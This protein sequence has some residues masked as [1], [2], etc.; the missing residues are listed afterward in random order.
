MAEEKKTEDKAEE[1][2]E[3]KKFKDFDSDMGKDPSEFSED[4]KKYLSTFLN[5]SEANDQ[6]YYL[7]EW[8]QTAWQKYAETGEMENNA[9]DVDSV[10]YK[11]IAT[12]ARYTATLI[13][14]AYGMQMLPDWCYTSKQKNNI[15]W[16]K[17]KVK[18][19]NQKQIMELAEKEAKKRG[20]MPDEENPAKDNENAKESEGKEN[21]AAT[22][23]KRGIFFGWVRK[24]SRTNE[25]SAANSSRTVIEVTQEALMDRA[26]YQEMDQQ[27]DDAALVVQE[28]TVNVVSKKDLAEYEVK[29]DS[30]PLTNFRDNQ[31]QEMTAAELAARA[32]LEEQQ[33]RE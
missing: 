8:Q 13:F 17:S 22:K 31:E 29:E 23:K 1:K 19:N 30:G 32:A 21:E 3:E 27:L 20:L 5:P 28:G 10:E 6:G 14:E 11:K 12:N 25:P 9:V 18:E 33:D 4:F 7:K 16:V 26:D 24:A 2:T 15:N